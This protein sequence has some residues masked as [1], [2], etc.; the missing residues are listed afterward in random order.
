MLPLGGA[1]EA[2]IGNQLFGGRNNPVF[3]GKETA[4]EREL[5]SLENSLK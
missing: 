5:W 1:G 3:R 2:S 4:R